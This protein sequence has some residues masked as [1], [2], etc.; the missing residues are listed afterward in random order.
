MLAVS[1]GELVDD[2][3]DRWYDGAGLTVLLAR[4]REGQQ[5]SVL[6]PGARFGKPLVTNKGRSCP[7]TDWNY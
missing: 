1:A 2:W 4:Q 7:K 6:C 3:T 5:L